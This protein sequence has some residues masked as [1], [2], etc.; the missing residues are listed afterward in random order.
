LSLPQE[1]FFPRSELLAEDEPDG[2]AIAGVAPNLA[3]LVT[4]E[5][6]F[7]IVRVAYIV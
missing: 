2:S 4:G 5:S 7:E 6:S 1:R 3:A